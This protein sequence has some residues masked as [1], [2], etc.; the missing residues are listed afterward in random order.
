MVAWRAVS[1]QR[2]SSFWPAVTLVAGQLPARG[3]S[4]SA[5]RLLPP[6]QMVPSAGPRAGKPLGPSTDWGSHW[7]SPQFC[8]VPLAQ[9]T[10][11]LVGESV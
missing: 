11:R 7:I 10:W 2:K 5:K 9:N 8:T 3:S 6:A 1:F 4:S